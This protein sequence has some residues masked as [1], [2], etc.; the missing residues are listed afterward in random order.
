M[1]TPFQYKDSVKE[2][3]VDYNGH[4][5]DAAYAEV[6]SHAVDALMNYF[7]ITEDV[8]HEQKYTIFT[9]E[10]HL[11]YLQE[12]HQGEPITV[13]WQLL[14]HDAKRLH[15]FFKMK[16]SNGDLVA[17]SEQMLMGMDQH[18]GKPSPFLPF[19]QEK[20]DRIWNEHEHLEQ[21]KQ[22]GRVIGIRRK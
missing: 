2:H 20:I 15:V 22:A 10:T 6:F 9:L 12:V 13:E 3:W 7:G 4:M 11:C 18:L 17:T 21:P 5:N 8:I 1:N 14:D 16:N 19:I